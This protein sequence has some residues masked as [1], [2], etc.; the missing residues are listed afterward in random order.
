MGRKVDGE[1]EAESTTDLESQ[2]EGR[3][4]KLLHAIPIAES[5]GL[6]W[7]KKQRVDRPPTYQEKPPSSFEWSGT[8][9]AD[10]VVVEEKESA[11]EGAEFW[12]LKS[13]NPTEE[14]PDE[15]KGSIWGL[16][17]LLYILFEIVKG[18]FRD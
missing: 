11:K 10:S 12:F 7:K 14:E 16:F 9:S 13:D 4:L 8:S 5:R 17:I 1:L 15:K 3:G 18:F 2:L 6:Y